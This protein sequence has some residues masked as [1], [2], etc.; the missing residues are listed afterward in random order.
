MEKNIIQIHKNI[1]RCD[2]CGNSFTTIAN[3][4]KHFNRKNICEPLL[5]NIPIEELKEKYKVRKGCYKCENCG[6]EYKSANGKYKHK[7]KC[8]LNVALIEKKNIDKLETELKSVKDDKQELEE[9]VQ[10]LLLEKTQAFEANAKIINNTNNSHNNT[11]NYNTINVIIKNYGEEKEMSEQE[12]KRLVEVALKKCNNIAGVPWDA[13]NHV[14]QQKHFNP[15]YPENQNLKLTNI[16]SPIMDVYTNNKWRK[17]PFAE[18]IKIIIESLMEFIESKNHL[19][20]DIS[21]NYWEELYEKLEEFLLKGENKK[22]YNKVETSMKCQLYNETQ[23]I[24]E[25][26]KIK[27]GKMETGN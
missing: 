2:R 24:M 4:R 13:L 1:I 16:S 14:L 3:L 26:N 19:V 12:I 21:K 5:K 15:K 18:Q 7:K 11:N 9:K 10:Q 6:K 17:V 27:S 8:L 20:V 25:Y 22:Y 23:D